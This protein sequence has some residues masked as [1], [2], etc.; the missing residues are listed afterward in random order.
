MLIVGLGVPIPF[1]LL[2]KKWPKF[3]FNN[4][5]TPI[6]VAKLGYLR[7]GINSNV[8]VA[9][10]LAVFSQYYLRKYRP[11]WFREYK[12]E[13]FSRYILLKCSHSPFSFLL[14]A[15]LDGGT[16]VMIFVWTFAG[17]RPLAVYIPNLM[18]FLCASWWW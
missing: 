18:H 14:S 8:F 4:V 9:F 17:M 11:T 1:Y 6:L 12:Y 15:A 3:G 16:S 5:F 13:N 10:C 7:V 2:H